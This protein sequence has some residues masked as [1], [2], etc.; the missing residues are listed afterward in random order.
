MIQKKMPPSSL[1]LLLYE[2]GKRPCRKIN[3]RDYTEASRTNEKKMK[4]S[5][6]VARKGP[7][8]AGQRVG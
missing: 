2:K 1:E 8:E 6:D 7:Q 4:E 3:Q 5:Q